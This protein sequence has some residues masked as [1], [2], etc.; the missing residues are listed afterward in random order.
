MPIT[1]GRASW[2]RNQGSKHE[3]DQRPVSSPVATEQAPERSGNPRTTRG[4][5]GRARLGRESGFAHAR[6]HNRTRLNR[7]RP[8]TLTGGWTG[9]LIA[10][11]FRLRLSSVFQQH[12]LTNTRPNTYKH[13]YTAHHPVAPPPTSP[14]YRHFRSP[15]TWHQGPLPFPRSYLGISRRYFRLPQSPPIYFRG[16]R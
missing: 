1:I 7:H 15:P 10:P 11:S 14:R 2:A 12:D 9:S 5:E 8:R 13:T 6:H 16:T 3:T 4:G